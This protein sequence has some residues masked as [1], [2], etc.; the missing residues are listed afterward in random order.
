M[1]PAVSPTEC[2]T[3]GQI[4]QDNGYST[5]WVGKD[6]NVAEQDVASG[7]SH[8]NWPLQKGFDRFYGFIGGETN[9]WYPDLVEDNHFVDQPYSPEDGYHL[10]KD[11]ADQAL[12]LIRDQKASNPS[13]PWYMWFCPAPTMHRITLRRNTSTSTRASSTTATRPIASGFCRA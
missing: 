3:V 6:H 5:F 11:L 10:S 2:A 12:S 13:K 4:L 8:K 7:V 9:Q 1:R